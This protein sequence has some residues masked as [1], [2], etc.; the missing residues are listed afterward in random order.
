MAL[1]PV[2]PYLRFVSPHSTW[3]ACRAPESSRRWRRSVVSRHSCRKCEAKCSRSCRRSAY[4]LPM[5]RSQAQPSSDKAPEGHLIDHHRE[6]S[7]RWRAPRW[8]SRAAA[9]VCRSD[10][11]LQALAKALGFRS[12]QALASPC[13]VC[14]CLGTSVPQGSQPPR[15]LALAGACYWL[16]AQRGWAEV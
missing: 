10:L 1:R 11:R 7:V 14:P 12:G 8:R 3:V 6:V 15:C 4:V 2:D 16:L 13:T 9:R 5:S